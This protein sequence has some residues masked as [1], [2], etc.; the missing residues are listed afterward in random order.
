MTT[1]R[2]TYNNK[3]NGFNVR[4]PGET[5]FIPAPKNERADVIA[6]L[7][8]RLCDNPALQARFGILG[9]DS[10]DIR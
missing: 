2:L 10:F 3:A 5:C 1:L 8:R 4:G 9:E 7:A 6:Y